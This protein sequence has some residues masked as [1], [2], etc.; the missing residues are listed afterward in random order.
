MTWTMPILKK[1]RPVTIGRQRIWNALRVMKAGSV[2]EIAYAAQVEERDAARYLRLLRERARSGRFT[3][4]PAPADRS[5]AGLK[6]ACSTRTNAAPIPCFCRQMVNRAD[7][8]AFRQFTKRAWREEAGS[9]EIADSIASN[10][11]PLK[12]IAGNGGD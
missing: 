7:Q 11:R 3:A 10:S 1:S 6:S 2:F 8:A 5:T 9:V 4:A 12:C